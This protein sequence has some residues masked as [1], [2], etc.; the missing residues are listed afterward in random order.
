MAMQVKNLKLK[1]A[2]ISAKKLLDAAHVMWPARLITDVEKLTEIAATL[3]A[4]DYWDTRFDLPLTFDVSA[5]VDDMKRKFGVKNMEPVGGKTK[6]AVTKGK[7]QHVQQQ[8]VQR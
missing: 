8:P 1:N 2:S 3:N 5:L 7:T 6:Y 4:G